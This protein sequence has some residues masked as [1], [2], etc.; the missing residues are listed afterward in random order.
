LSDQS[1]IEIAH[2]TSFT[3]ASLSPLVDAAYA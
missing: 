2:V 3:P 1:L